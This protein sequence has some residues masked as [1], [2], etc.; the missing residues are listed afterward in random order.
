M[1]RIVVDD[2]NSI[3]VVAERSEAAVVFAVIMAIK[4]RL[5]EAVI[6]IFVKIDN[7]SIVTYLY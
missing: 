4:P 3:V 1:R 2:V 5:A 7:L 6:D